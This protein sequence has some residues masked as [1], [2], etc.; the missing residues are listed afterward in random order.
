MYNKRGAGRLGAAIGVIESETKIKITN[1]LR[2][3]KGCLNSDV[4]VIARP[5][6][7]VRQRM[8]Y[9]LNIEIRP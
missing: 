7:P 3:E 2:K 9:N 4:S 6:D 8:S 1:K 5:H